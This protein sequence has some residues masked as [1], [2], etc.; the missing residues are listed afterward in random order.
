MTWRTA[1]KSIIIGTISLALGLGTVEAGFSHEAPEPTRSTPEVGP[2][3][4]H[5]VVV[6]QTLFGAAV[7]AP[8]RQSYRKAR[9]QAD[10]RFGHLS[11]VRYF[12]PNLPQPWRQIKRN[13]GKRP[14]AISF[15][16]S[17]AEVL[18]GRYDKQLTSWFRHAPRHRITWWS[19]EPE[20]EGEVESGRFTTT[21]FRRA[22]AH[23]SALSYRADNPNLRATLMLMCYT[24]TKYSHRNWRDYYPGRHYVRVLAWDCYNQRARLGHYEK[25]RRMLHRA[26]RL[27]HRQHKAWAVAETG[28]T[29]VGKNAVHRRA[30]WLKRLGHYAAHHHAQFMTYFDSTVGGDYRL[31][32][33]PS[34]DAWRDVIDHKFG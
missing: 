3:S 10:R 12:D 18:K 25:P 31:R 32:D 15:R 29:L 1:T 34:I 20:P 6:R 24:L 28:S 5:G 33:T 30:R 17:P 23:L 2:P 7:Q 26:K 8:G 21:Q 19:Y 13:V 9:S 14:V 27:S 22:F 16:A 4:G 11:V